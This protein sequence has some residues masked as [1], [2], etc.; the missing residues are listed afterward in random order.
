MF[1]VGVRYCGGCNPQIDRSK[2]VREVKECLDK[3]GLEVSFSTEKE[4]FFDIVCLISGFRHAC[5]EKESIRPNTR[6]RM[7]SV[8]GDLVD[9]LY[10]TEREIP[11]YLTKILLT[12]LLWMHSIHSALN[13]CTCGDRDSDK[14]TVS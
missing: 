10:L 6:T 2:I 13:N 11:F 1:S 8:K 5:A 4:D 9:D 3:H 14:K 7:L 12:S